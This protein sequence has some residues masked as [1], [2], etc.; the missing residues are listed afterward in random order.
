MPKQT[1]ARKKALEKCK[2]I[3]SPIFWISI[4]TIFI[5]L[6][7][8]ASNDDLLHALSRGILEEKE[9]QQLQYAGQEAKLTSVPNSVSYVQYLNA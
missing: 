2:P 8:L 5:V 4:Y 6:D 3:H 7:A 9:L 1:N